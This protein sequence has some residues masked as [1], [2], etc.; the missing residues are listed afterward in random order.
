MHAEVSTPDAG[1]TVLICEDE[2]L[3]ALRIRGVLAAGGYRVVGTAGD[4][5]SAVRLA[6][7]LHPDVI[8]MDVQMP[9]LDGISAAEQVLQE[10]AIPIVILTAYGD[11]RTVRRAVAAG[12]AGYLVKPV[13]DEQI[14][15]TIT[16]ALRQFATQDQLRLERDSVQSLA[17]ALE[18]EAEIVRQRAEELRSALRREQDVARAL[19][20]S[21]LAPVPEID[22][23]R[24]ETCYEP[25]GRADLVGGDFFDFIHLPRNQLGI[26]VGDVCGKG[27]QAA[28][29][30]AQARYLLRAY[31]FEDA[32]PAQ[33]LARTNRALCDRPDSHFTFVTVFY[34]VLDLKS[35]RFTY[36]S[37]GQEE[38]LLCASRFEACH[39]LD[40]T[41][42]ALGIARDWDWTEH[43]LPFPPGAAL[44]LITD[45]LTEARR[46]RV[47]F[48]I[49]AVERAFREAYERRD[50]TLAGAISRA[51]HRFAGAELND[52]LAVVVV[53][54]L[55]GAAGLTGTSPAPGA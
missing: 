42:G 11:E 34:G 41:G 48:G 22:G 55:P 36:A 1:S 40:P 39:R 15:P 53:E 52:D 19:A 45:G 37:A 30:T 12:A 51:V 27:L 21:F 10:Q 54:Q 17:S 28:R 18:N 38:G 7:E 5:E 20:E 13:L 26:V 23:L 33:V 24:I 50:P 4:G 29:I 32:S 46:D 47:Q 44:A 9:K 35:F 25:A 31:A 2:G 43:V 6:R 16:M 8:L 3:T 49:E 14:I